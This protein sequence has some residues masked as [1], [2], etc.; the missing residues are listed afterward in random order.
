MNGVLAE[1]LKGVISLCSPISMLHSQ[2]VLDGPAML[3]YR[4]TILSSLKRKYRRLAKNGIRE[5]NPVL[6]NTSAVQKVRTFYEWDQTVVC[7]RYGYE[8]VEAY[9]A[10]VSVAP[11]LCD[12]PCPTLMVFTANDPL[13]PIHQL[14][15]YLKSVNQHT[16]VHILTQGGHLGFSGKADLRH[17]GRKGVQ[18]QVSA[19]IEQKTS[20]GI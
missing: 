13:I 1:Q 5:G 10:D 16:D 18:N 7:P 20:S 12:L 8:S 14:K 3:P 4:L 19:W 6:S 11:H 15:P 9:Y 2:R 17:P